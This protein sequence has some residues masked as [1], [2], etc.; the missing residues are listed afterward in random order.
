MGSPQ[1]SSF[2]VFFF[3]LFINDFVKLHRRIKEFVDDIAMDIAMAYE[4]TSETQLA[5]AITHDM[6]IVGEFFRINKLTMS[7]KKT[8]FMI[9]HTQYEK[10]IYP[11]HIVIDDIKIERVYSNKYLGLILDDSLTFTTHLSKLRTSLL[12]TVTALWKLRFALPT[13]ILSLGNRK[14]KRNSNNPDPPKSS[15]TCDRYIP[16][17]TFIATLNKT[18]CLFVV[19]MHLTSAFSSS[20]PWLIECAIN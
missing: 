6:R 10:P 7:T 4:I 11:D 5:N 19:S 15:P 17:K 12:P 1:G 18:F 8:K 14:P 3:I 9:F 20:R 2:S 13:N 16:L